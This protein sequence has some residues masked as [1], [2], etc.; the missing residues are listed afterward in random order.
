MCHFPVDFL[1][2]FPLATNRINTQF[3]LKQASRSERFPSLSDFFGCNT[4]G[5]KGSEG[6]GD[7]EGDGDKEEDRER[8]YGNR[9]GS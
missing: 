8:G 3:L 9:E 2:P 5:D 6:D 1:F 4:K 7:G